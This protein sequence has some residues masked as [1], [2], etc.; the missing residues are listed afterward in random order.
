MSFQAE[1]ILQNFAHHT[2]HKI[3]DNINR[4]LNKKSSP[5][6]HFSR[7]AFAIEHR[8]RLNKNKTIL[9][10][11]LKLPLTYSLATGIINIESLLNIVNKCD[12]DYLF[13]KYTVDD[14]LMLRA[15]L[16][17]GFIERHATIIM[18]FIFAL[19]AGVRKSYHQLFLEYIL[20]VEYFNEAYLTRYAGYIKVFDPIVL[21]K[22]KKI[23]EA[24]AFKHFSGF[25]PAV[26]NPYHLIK[27]NQ[28]LLK[29]VEKYG[30][31]NYILANPGHP[32]RWNNVCSNVNFKFEHYL[33]NQQR[34]W[35]INRVIK[36]VP[37][38][39]VVGHLHL[40]VKNRAYLQKNVSNTPNTFIIANYYIYI[41]CI[42][43]V[44]KKLISEH[45]EPDQIK[46]II[47]LFCDKVASINN[48]LARRTLRVKYCFV[49]RDLIDYLKPTIDF[50]RETECL[51]DWS[52]SHIM[53]SITEDEL[54]KHFVFLSNMGQYLFDNIHLNEH[55]S[56]DTLKSLSDYIP[57]G[58]MYWHTYTSNY[59]MEYIIDNI[60]CNWDWD[61]IYA[62]YTVK[63]WDFIH[64]LYKK[65]KGFARNFLKLRPPLHIIKQI[66]D[67]GCWD[68]EDIFKLMPASEILNWLDTP[69]IIP[70]YME[71]A[72]QT[73]DTKLTAINTICA[74]L[75]YPA[76]TESSSTTLENYLPMELVEYVYNYL[77]AIL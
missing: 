24:F 45:V 11:Y 39:D 73:L 44:L 65:N 52:Y 77:A 49:I 6:L 26:K 28:T 19:A 5:A 36:Y 21:L 17:H 62:N 20:T 69:D 18:D 15:Y 41:G 3:Y 35:S 74:S 14:L 33:N 30:D 29:Y 47:L 1:S 58:S 43:D 8:V 31:I 53:K 59:S 72:L 42:P 70:L 9:P 63:N 51:I 57:S 37:F 54:K 32:W 68:M 25:D 48:D 76:A 16:H 27:W 64:K 50:A 7:D 40:C 23:S 46:K 2:L 10:N 13:K 56:P 75:L 12:I 34:A 22:E 55:L 4:M 67:P 61:Y 60:G 71:T 66:N 38:T